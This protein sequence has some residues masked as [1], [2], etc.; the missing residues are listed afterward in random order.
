MDESDLQARLDGMETRLRAVEELLNAAVRPAP[1][2]SHLQPP[3][4][5]YRWHSDG[6]MMHLV[7]EV[8]E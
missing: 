1:R 7:E 5:G 3:P 8:N 4:P 6:L 2:L